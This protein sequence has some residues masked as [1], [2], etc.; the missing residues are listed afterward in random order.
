MCLTGAR[1][2]TCACADIR[3]A[4]QREQSALRMIAEL[5][6]QHET[7]LQT[8]AQQLEAQYADASA[9]L[10]LAHRAKVGCPAM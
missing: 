9:Q 7:A 2:L 10:R 3:L 4:E 5:R 1:T 8:A 6:S